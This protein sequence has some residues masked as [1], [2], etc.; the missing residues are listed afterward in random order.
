MKSIYFRNFL[1]TACMMMMSFLILA[2]A[3]VVLGRGFL[4]GERRELLTKT[5]DETARIARASYTDDGM[6]SRLNFTLRLNITSLAE[7]TDSHIFICDGDGVIISC[8]DREFSCAHIGKVMTNELLSQLRESGHVDFISNLNGFYEGVHYISV[9]PVTVTDS[10]YP[11]GYVFASADG[12]RITGAWSSFLLLLLTTAI[13]IMMVC[14]A[15]AYITSKQQALPINEIAAAARSFAHGEFTVRVREGDRNDGEIGELA[16]AFNAMAESI[17]QS[18]ERRRDFIANV[19]HELKTPMTTISGFADGILDGTIPPENQERY[20]RTISEET[21]RLS[22]LV[23]HML[24]LSR[25]QSADAVE[26]LSG[27]FDISETLRQTLLYFEEKI[28]EKGLDVD[29]QLPENSMAVLGDEDSIKQVVYNLLENAI[30]FSTPGTA[31]GLSLWKQGTKAYISVRNRGDEIPEDDLPR[32][33]ERF[34]KSD[35]SR[36]LDR[37][38]VGLGLHIVKSILNNHGEDISVVSRDGETEFQFTLSLAAPK[39]AG[40]VQKQSR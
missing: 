6:L 38:G 32:V 10:D 23:R 34:H 35:H 20:L 19:S 39:S 4:A 36:S 3:F 29:A 12:M 25:I 26:L 33:F 14:V 11:V 18:E 21:K 7:T 16:Q 40:K 9:T 2:V 17:E 30:K 1:V 5:A 24:E 28:T 22:R 13:C 31:L 8:S 27:E 15:M 37:D